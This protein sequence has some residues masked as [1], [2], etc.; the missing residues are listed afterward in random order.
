MKS[1]SLTAMRV[2]TVARCLLTLCLGTAAALG[3]LLP[4]PARAGPTEIVQRP[5]TLQSAPVPN[6]ML[7][8]DDSGSMSSDWLPWPSDF[9][10]SLF[11]TSAGFSADYWADVAN[12]GAAGTTKGYWLDIVRRFAFLNPIHYNPATTYKPWND[13]GKPPASNFPNSDIGSYDGGGTFTGGTRNDQRHVMVAGVRNPVDTSVA[14]DLFRRPAGTRNGNLCL[15]TAIQPRMNCVPQATSES[16]WACTPDPFL[17]ESVCTA[18]NAIAPVIPA[19][20]VNL[21]GPWSGRHQVSNYRFVE[22]DRDQ[23]A[24]TYP[25]PVDPRTGIQP[26]RA[27]CANPVVCTFAEEAANYANWYTYYRN[28]L[29]SAIAVTSDVMSGIVSP[30]RLGYGRNN[31]F[32]NGPQQWAA[33]PS[34]ATGFLLPNIDGQPAP[35]YIVRG[36]RDFTVGSAE[37]QELF[38]W[39]FQLNAIGWTPNREAVNAAGEYFSRSDSLGPWSDNPGTGPGG[40]LADKA[41]RRSYT[42]LATDGG[43]TDAGGPMAFGSLFGLWGAGPHESDSV[44]GPVITG[45]G[46]LSSRTYQY[47]PSSEKVFGGPSAGQSD[48]FTDVAHFYW[49]RDLRSDLPNQKQPVPWG[50]AAGAPYPSGFEDPSTWQNMSTMI[51]GFGLE[52][53]IANQTVVDAM[54]NN[55]PVAWPPSVLFSDPNDRTKIVDTQR[56]AFAS[57]GAFFTATSASE[58][59]TALTAAFERI[60]AQASAAASLSVS[61]AVIQSVD[62]LVFEAGY[63]SR[64]WSGSLRAL[65]AM[66][67]LAGTR[68]V[69]WTADVPVPAARKL[70][71]TTARNTA[72]NFAWTSLT[73]AQQTAIG[74]PQLMDY[75]R[76]DQSNELPAGPY[77]RRSTLLGTIVHAS[78]LHSKATNFGYHAGPTAG[79]TNYGTYLDWKRTTRR[80]SVMVGSNEGMLH[81]FDA[82]TGTELF[83]FAPRA[84]IPKMAA[85]ASP[86]YDHQY[87]V[88]GPLS[89]GDAYFGGAWK[90]V[91]VGT[92][93]AGPKSVY[94]LDVTDPDAFGTG[95]V[96]FDLTDADEPDLGHVMGRPLIASTKAGKWVAIV[97]NGYESASYRAKLLVIDLATGSVLRKIDT[98]VGADVAGQRNGLGPVTPIYNARRD[99]IGLYGGDKLG[100]VWKFDLSDT[101]VA[102]WKIAR[103]GMAPA[104]PLFTAT[105][106]G[107]NPQPI[108][109]E[110]RVSPHPLGGLYLSIGTGKYFETTDATDSS[111]QSIYML[112]DD[113]NTVTITKPQLQLATLTDVSGGDYRQLSGATPINWATKKGWYLNLVSAGA[114]GGAGG[115]ERVIA[116][117]ISYGG[118]VSFTT[119]RPQNGDPCDASGTS[120]AYVFDLASG[121]TRSVFESQSA[122]IVARRLAEG[123][124]GGAV[125]LYAPGSTSG[126]VSSS[127]NAGELSGLSNDTRYTVTGSAVTSTSTSTCALGGVSTGQTSLAVPMQCAGTLPLRVWRDLR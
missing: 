79:G 43:W 8:M 99:V 93:G 74:S 57:R 23:P 67:L 73:A 78:P 82:T 1:T 36:V 58:L 70:I 83:A 51:I 96:L 76:G 120:Y 29:F 19:H 52:S 75:L 86:S 21:V 66:A 41:C 22:I 54:K 92:S 15:A 59:G 47:D 3:V 68:N 85:L 117:P 124:L 25:V 105:D 121:L 118:K 87:L 45:S 27:D 98:G 16:G 9:D 4:T 104:A 31:Y 55:T 123:V 38:D 49:S 110:I 26:Q 6:V 32:A 108:T 39:L 37:R 7:I 18:W 119:F 65:E 62:D 116:A 17:T 109:T 61:T 94:A 90:T 88:D 84:G 106:P 72:T 102:N 91:V 14:P 100:N 89:E 56:A 20:Y 10:A 44:M 24:K 101:N 111:V 107:G 34:T 5:L 48:T 46:S 30:L 103:V 95:K 2:R 28:R 35:G 81:S 126:I 114:P 60:Q 50:S 97:G 77:R 12:Q 71:T 40:G 42:I 115:G 63:L 11:I 122:A 113:G 53:P 112:R 80:A 13:N 127:I 69:R 33:F 125:P 64:E